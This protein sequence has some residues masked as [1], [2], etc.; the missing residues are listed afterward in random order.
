MKSRANIWVAGGI[1]ALVVVLVGCGSQF[2]AGGK[3]HF[4]QNRFDRA[5]ENFDKA[6]AEQPNNGEAHMWRG[7][8]LAELERDDEAVVELRKAVELDPLQEEMVR[9]SFISYWSKRYNSALLFAKEAMEKTGDDQKASL[10]KAR[11]RFERAIVFAPDSVQNYSNLGKVLYQ[12][13][14]MGQA[15]AM[16]DKSRQLSAG[17]PDLQQFLFTLYKFFGEQSL[18]DENRAGYER[19]LA[20]LHNAESMPTA[21]QGDQIEVYF[22]IATAYY[23]LSDSVAEAERIPT[24]QKAAEYY[25]KVLALAP[26]DPDALTNLAYV[27]SDEGQG[28]AAL[29][30]GQQRYDQAPW[31]SESNLFMER[32][33]K[34]AGNDKMANGH[35]LMAQMM[36][37]GRRQPDT[38]ARD[39]AQAAGPTSDALKVLRDRGI[40]QEVRKL[41]AGDNPYSVWCYWS[42][43]RAYIFRGGREQVRI[44]FKPLTPEQLKTAMQS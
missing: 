8:T 14:D 43:G 11:E 30:R 15:M 44:S 3:L 13:G 7:R 16:F 17:R 25:E 32:L 24:L 1:L 23:S 18:S 2:L 38:A 42:D 20:L 10:E 21:N 27:L 34:A 28:D 26:D 35:I 36:V 5:L 22:N 4:S 6:I 37:Q 29:Q 9:N 33:Y 19:A 12:L 39:E 31:D 41:E 40:P